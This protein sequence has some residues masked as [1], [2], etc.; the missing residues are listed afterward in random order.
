MKTNINMI[1][2]LFQ[3]ILDVDE[4]DNESNFFEEG[5]D[6]FDAL[7]L[8]NSL[9]KNLP[10]LTIFEN[11]TP[12]KLFN[13]LI[14]NENKKASQLIPLKN[15]D[16]LVDEGEIAFVGVPFGGGDPTSYKDMFKNDNNIM[17]YGVNF[18][19]INI[20]ELNLELD[21]KSIINEINNINKEKIIIYG[22]CA[23]GATATYLA[24]KLE[25]KKIYLIIGASSPIL[26][27]DSSIEESK[28]TSNEEWGEYLRSIGGFEG[29]N[30]TEIR[31]MLD[32]GRRD[33][34]ISTEMYRELLESNYEKPFAKIIL[35]DSDPSIKSIDN[36]INGWKNFVEINEESVVK[37]GGHYFLKSHLYDVENIIYSYI[38][39][40]DN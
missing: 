11:P 39:R 9:D 13:H 35:G 2:H 3:D 17:V 26:N 24:T 28:K 12:Q 4:I 38:K 6:S 30:D 36:A 14:S 22:H 7:R 23:G 34:I 31:G 37:N 29:L 8:M 19:D 40:E 20:N 25:N 5:G 16:L 32:R 27:P 33:H 18:G 21:F 1:K 15:K 10:I